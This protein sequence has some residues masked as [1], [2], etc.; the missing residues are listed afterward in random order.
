MANFFIQARA[1]R[2]NSIL[3]I[4]EYG[5]INADSD[6]AAIEYR[7]L[8]NEL[9]ALDAPIDKIGIQA[10]MSRNDISKADIIRRI[11]I[12]AET[13]LS[14]EITEF[15]TRDDANQIS[16]EQ[17][18]IIFQDMLEA[19]FE[20]TAVD[21]FIVWDFGTRGIGVAMDLFSTRTGT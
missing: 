12:L 17:Q 20:S 4:N 1:V 13:G 14:I 15:D 3:S 5:I 10:H 16:P 2:P 11:N 18:K 9:L 7:D 19:A 6:S 8:V 21:G